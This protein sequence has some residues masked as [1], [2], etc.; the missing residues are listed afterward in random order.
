MPSGR[1]SMS[2]VR[3]ALLSACMAWAFGTSA[4]AA[5]RPAPQSHG[6]WEEAS[7]IPPPPRPHPR[8]AGSGRIAL[9][10]AIRAGLQRHEATRTAPGVPAS[11]SGSPQDK[12][13]SVTPRPP[14]ELPVASPSVAP[15]PADWS[16]DEIAA[17]EAQCDGLL[18]S[19]T[20]EA[21]RLPAF[22]EGACGAPVALRLGAIG[23]RQ[24][25]RL[26]PPAVTNCAMT[27]RLYQWLETVAQ[28]AART[29]LGA[30]IVGLR[31]ASAYICRNRYNDPAAKIS[32]HA[33][34]NA[35]DISAFELSDGRLVDVKTFWGRIVASRPQAAPPVA[36]RSLTR[37]D[38]ER[39]SVPTVM[40][41]STPTGDVV[42]PEFTFLKALHAGACGVFGT[43]LGP[44]ANAAHHDH[45]HF[46]MKAR[47][48][49]SFCQ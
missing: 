7:G 30:D 43:V 46:D 22:R 49:T 35:L 33:Y 16:P 11:A 37:L 23:S 47:R 36:E 13:P 29:S 26:T 17:A 18:A 15:A 6:I 44:E 9:D 21:T 34:A 27:A 24:A 28:P 20:A 5:G 39:T 31:T 32:E 10:R 4:D 1:K 48:A 40:P 25:A 2:V 8:R 42:T 38:S 19:I 3:A 12:L 41:S 45:F 14:A